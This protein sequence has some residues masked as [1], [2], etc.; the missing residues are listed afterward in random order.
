M[1]TGANDSRPVVQLPPLL[2]PR[3]LAVGTVPLDDRE[4]RRRA[5]AGDGETPQAMDI[6]EV[7]R[8]VVVVVEDEFLVVLARIRPLD[9]RAAVCRAL[10]F[11]RDGLLVVGIAATN[12]PEPCAVDVEPPRLLLPRA[13]HQPR[14]LDDGYAVGGLRSPDGQVLLGLD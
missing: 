3:V 5:A 6:L 7:E 8:S 4:A 10:V 12:G 14:R 9:H 11:D 1:L 2:H 13:L